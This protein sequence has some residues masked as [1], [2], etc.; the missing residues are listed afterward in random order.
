MRKQQRDHCCQGIDRDIYLQKQVVGGVR[1]A[2]AW[3]YCAGGWAT[4]AEVSSAAAGDAVSAEGG[5]H[6][7]S[8]AGRAYDEAG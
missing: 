5:H 6:T 2:A 8:P 3:L 7:P 4:E 1:E